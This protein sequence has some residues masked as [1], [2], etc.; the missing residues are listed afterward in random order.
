MSAP[1]QEADMGA[2]VAIEGRRTAAIRRIGAGRSRW[3]VLVESWPERDAYHG[4]LLFR[5]DTPAVRPSERESAALLSG[6]SHEDVLSRAHE[7]PEAQL[8][9]VLNSFG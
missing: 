9:R 1:K 7:L 4:R 6:C 5:S 8:Q 2:A 3:T